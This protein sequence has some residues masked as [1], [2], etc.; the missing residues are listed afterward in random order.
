MS[1]QAEEA[2]TRGTPVTRESFLEWKARFDKEIAAKKAREDEER[3]KALSSKEREEYKRIAHR[4]TGILRLSYTC[5][6]SF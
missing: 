3:L 1:P 4:P 6:L 5:S 2:R